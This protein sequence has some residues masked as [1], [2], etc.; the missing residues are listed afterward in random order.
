MSAAAV[1][2]VGIGAS[3][4]GLSA[5]ET[6]FEQLPPDTGAAFVV[7]QHLS[8]DYQSHMRDLLGRRTR[9]RTEQITETLRPRPNTVYLLPPAK[10]VEIEDGCLRLCDRQHTGE[11]NLP[12]DKFFRSLARQQDRQL[13]AVILSGTGS[14]GSEGIVAVHS[15]GGL[16][17]CQDEDSAQFNGMPLNALKTETV[18]IAAP[19]A[20][21][22]EALVSYLG[23]AAIDAVISQSVPAMEHTDLE[24]VY[25]R[26]DEACGVDFTQ[27]KDGTFTRR[28]S[29]RMMLCKKEQLGE[30]LEL[31]DSDP[32]ELS[33]LADDL[34]IGVTRFFRDPDG[35]HRLARRAIRTAAAAK[36]DGDEFRAWIA[37]CATGQEA[38][39]VAML[40]HQERERTGT[41]F[42][43][44]IFAT[45]VH[46]DAIR[47]AQRGLYPKESLAEIP[48][49][50]QEKYLVS[51]PQGFEI[52]RAVRN[53]IVFARHDV[54]QDAPFTHMDLIT[55]RN[56][57]IYLV[58]EAQERVL[59]MFVHALKSRGVLWLGP[60]ETPG[61]LTDDFVSLDKHW[62]LFQK[63]RETRMPLDLRLRNRPLTN[64]RLAPRPSPP[65]SPSTALIAS[66]DRILDLYAP[67]GLLID[68]QHR[69]LQIFGDVTRYVQLRPGRLHGTVEDVLVEVLQS[70]V[71]VALQQIHSEQGHVVSETIAFADTT[72]QLRVQRFQHAGRDETHYLIT[73]STMVSPPPADD[74]STEVASAEKDSSSTSP[75]HAAMGNGHG[76]SRGKADAVSLSET[77]VERTRLLEMELEFTRENLQATIEEVETTNEELQSSN[78][79]LTSSN[80]ELQ[81]T[82]E[83]L[84]SV[85][86]ELHATNAESNRRLQLLTEITHDL[87]SVL[88]ESDVGIVLVDTDLNIR[89]VTPAA[90]DILLMRRSEDDQTLHDY[91]DALEEVHLVDLV[92]EVQAKH[93]LVEVEALD[94]RGEPILLRAAPYRDRSGVILTMT[95]L[96]NVKETASRLRSLTS[97]VQDSTDA[98]IGIDLNQRI[99]SWNRGAKRLFRTD[100]DVGRGVKL[101][102]VVPQKIQ[103]VCTE[104]MSELTR[105]GEVEPQEV[106]VTLFDK[107]LTLLI[108]VTP[109]LDDL[110]RVASAA[111]TLYDVTTVRFTEE[112]LRLRTRAIDAASN[113]FL[114]VDALAEDMPIVY[115]NRGF[116]E[117]TGYSPRDVSGRNCRFLQGPGTD[118]EV[119]QKIRDAIAH[120]H[121]CRVTILNYRRDG[122]PFYNDL[123]VTPVTDAAG[124]VT[125][126]VGIQSDITD[127]VHAAERLQAS[128]L[129]Y[130]STFE[131]A[132][133][134]IAHI[135][136]DGEWLKCNQKVA[137]LLGYTMEELNQKTFQELTHPDDRDEDL[138]LFNRMVAGEIPGYSIEKRYFHRDGHIVWANLTTSLKRG[139]DGRPESCISLIED[140][141][142][143]RATEQKLMASRAIITEVIEKSSDPFLSFDEEGLVQAANP[144]AREL[145]GRPSGLI[146]RP[147]QQ[148]FDASSDRPLL[149]A[150]DRVR[151]SQQSETA[152]YYSRQNHRWYDARVFPVDGGAAMHLTDVTRRKETESY[153][154]A[155]RV[156]AEDASQ[157]KSN[158][159]TNLSHE[160]RSPM[161]AILGFADLA[162][163]DLREGKQVDRTHLETVIR[164]GRFLLRII[165]D[166]LDLSKVEAGRL[167]V[168]KSRFRMLPMLGDILELMRHRSE[169][170]GLPLTIEFEGPVPERLRSDRSRVEQILVNLIGN[171]L[172]FTVKGSV[173]VVVGI[174]EGVERRVCFRVID[175][176]IGISEANL[177]KLF[178][179]FTQVHDR[180]MV[181]V[182]GTGLGLVISKRLANLL[183]GDISV[184]SQEGV[185]SE[186][187]LRLPVDS[188]EPLCTVS[189]DD[190]R[191]R[192]AGT[193]PL[194]RISGRVLIADD[195][196]DLRLM[197]NRL[198]TRAGATVVEASNGAEAVVAVRQAEQAGE[199]FD[200]LLMDMQMP[201]LDGREATQRIR[202]QG[203][204]MPIIALTAGAT[205]EEVNEALAAGCSEFV[206]KPV[207]AADLISRVAKLIE[208]HTP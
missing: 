141:T 62:R 78:E 170:S 65:R 189:A 55:C 89:R 203:Y 104:M 5:L 108:R 130:R 166:I 19:V 67:P 37:G 90:A 139:L 208:G 87:E 4:G 9:M 158:F 96:R 181:G 102:D 32:N 34:M 81:S 63:Q 91:A 43:I 58:D 157:A 99:T 38:Y 48:R 92:R 107:P 154:E 159:L 95:N 16:V 18:H 30:Y 97:I 146:G 201:E 45:D 64:K 116:Q 83:E 68:D 115:A 148:C 77:H 160:I 126:F 23:G 186:F 142:A 2:I 175:T 136:L 138:R 54:L 161:S 75:A 44:K 131:N 162:L 26:L 165:N 128:E 137:D 114:I 22:A 122:S 133:I 56:L 150:L 21:L 28:L 127:V 193:Q 163:R 41:D 185:G 111:I 180:K 184:A 14:D 82:N 112:Q 113:G 50:F 200:C 94:R 36:S 106:T 24:A 27:Y 13:A 61:D 39:S 176:G 105:R 72:L 7:V 121:S 149:V 192:R 29:R 207:D 76:S 88:K 35:Y 10:H 195:A 168:R 86:E 151:R 202:E 183:D 84:H 109:V 101:D 171:A 188:T 145:T 47:F 70:P 98:I 73:F 57:L 33:R 103:A 80:E 85:N 118:P 204:T 20:E 152:E 11:L 179:T 117:L 15:A 119:V 143:R 52:N 60:S 53:S 177:G 74:S 110:E 147:Y 190:L 12:I 182:E 172:K 191:P 134:G 206:A 71:L 51:T 156:A 1:P 66:Y 197:T 46:P 17:L 6:L 198:L 123:I 153:L 140:I 155:A 132:A 194:P 120:K 173:R 69:L 174:E 205:A 40:I 129:E 100:L 59:N 25:Q 3:A 187:T 124:T 49:E 167:E 144:A 93:E 135:G 178:Q 199:P 79:E 31:L 196:R 42:E 164:N 8:P 125:H 169:S